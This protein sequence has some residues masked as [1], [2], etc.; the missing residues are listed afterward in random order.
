MAINSVGYAS[1][2]LGQ[3]VRN[4]NNQLTTLQSQL[5]TG[6]KSTTYAGMGANEG[7]AI[8]ARAQLANISAFTDTMTKVNTNINVTSTALQSISNIG[9][10]IQNAAGSS[11]QSLN[12]AGQTVAQQNAEAQFS[13]M[14]GVLNTQS[15]DRYVFSGSA[16]DTPSVAP[17]DDIM[18]GTV[19][20]D[21]LK[22]VIADRNAADLG[23]NGQGRI[24]V[25]QPTATS[26]SVAEDAAPSAFGLKLNTINSSLTGATVTGPTGTPPAV[27]IQL[28]ATN[29]SDGDKIG[30]SFKLP[31]G[32]SET[33]QLTASSATPTPAGSFAIG[34][35]PAATAANLNAA[36]TS[37]VGTLAK[38]SL[39][40]AS[41]VA[42]SDN[43]FDSPPLRVGT[44]PL[45]SATTLVDGSANTVS[46]YTG[47]SGSGSARGSSTALIDQSAT[48][49]YGARAN[50]QAIRWQLQNI[51]VLAAVT[52][53][54]G[55]NAAA[56]VSALSSRVAQ[57]LTTQSG[58]Q[59]VQDMQSDFATAQTT[60]KN[61]TARQTQTQSMLQD[62]VDQAESVSPDEVA[63]QLLALQTN[64]QASYQTTAMLAQLTLTKY[65]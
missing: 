56:Q 46:W 28:G 62:V 30:F 11:S 35:T 19:T 6:K 5:T 44:T 10:Q 42:A 8:A 33:V 50:E 20:Q 40:A 47:E 64:L 61:A 45:G 65:L 22:Q 59:T 38:T 49:K 3:A 54:P 34:A 53:T 39:V 21:G 4:L 25:S 2:I 31:D 15:G 14:L 55:A 24:V 17:A 12:S 58:Q 29:P 26:V 57:N 51:A 1:T 32:T 43:F 37:S 27:S 52:T 9:T 41:A 36:L 16:L 18:N 13:A 23:T 60:M 7:F 48:V 63:S